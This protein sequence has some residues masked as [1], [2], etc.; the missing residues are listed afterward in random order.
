MDII[1]FRI[2]WSSCGCL[3]SVLGS[4]TWW[5]LKVL[6]T[7]MTLWLYD[8]YCFVACVCMHRTDEELRRSYDARPVSWC[9]TQKRDMILQPF[10]QLTCLWSPIPL[11]LLQICLLTPIY[12][13]IY[14]HTHYRITKV[15]KDPSDHLVQPPT[16]P[17]MPTNCVP[18]CHMHTVLEHLQAQW[19]PEQLCHCLTTPSEKAFFPISNLNLPWH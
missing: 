12:I 13:Y 16:H 17:T 4:S 14:I 19:L 10:L 9:G 18:Q 1:F 5:P 3:G 7:K 6:P 11:N 8:W 15:G 2:P